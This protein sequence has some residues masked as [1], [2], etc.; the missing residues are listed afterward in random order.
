M[1]RAALARFLRARRERLRPEDVGL[2]SGERRRVAGLQR[3]EVAQLAL[4]SADYY[5]RLEQERGPQPSLQMLASLT[6][7]LRLSRSER[8]HLH[9]LAGHTP[10]ERSGAADHVA[11]ALQRVLD[12]LD[13][14]PALVITELDET[15]AQNDLARALFGARERR[16]G[17]ERSGAWCWFVHPVSERA[18]YP[19]SD[20]DRQSR[21]IV[22][23]LRAVAGRGGAGSRAARLVDDL[24]ERSAEFARLWDL[25]EVAERFA[26]HKVVVHPAVGEIEVDC[27]VLFTEDR[28]QAL[29][30]LTPEPGSEAAEKL[31][32]LSVLGPLAAERSPA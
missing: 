30:T 14:I 1:D 2:P 22:A 11:P 31:R 16:I 13:D 18:V 27:Q 19:A 26:D 15:L 25:E 8:D 21:A 24:R 10:P 20:H 32:M 4:M 29:L 17:P 12:R 9:R 6:R 7:A 23:N 28:S 3:E 5:T